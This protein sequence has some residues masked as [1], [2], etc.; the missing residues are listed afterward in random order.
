MKRT[1]SLSLLLVMLFTL[2]FSVAEEITPYADS[3]FYSAY[4]T[5]STRKDA[6]FVGSTYHKQK[7]I[8]VI[9]CSLEKKT[10]AYSWMQVTILTPPEDIC[11]D[12]YSYGSLVSYAEEIGV[13]TYRIKATF[14]ADGHTITRYSNERTFN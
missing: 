6:T 13:G 4:I 2:S 11:R 1:I 5:L 3:V 14:D 9:A 12:T 8:S 7:E 10:G